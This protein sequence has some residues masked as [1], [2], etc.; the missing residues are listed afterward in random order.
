MRNRFLALATLLAWPSTALADETHSNHFR[1]GQRA[2]GMGG[3]LTAVVGDTEA[4]WYNPAGLAFVSGAVFSGSIQFYGF[5]ERVVNGALR[6]PDAPQ[7]DAEST[8]FLPAPSSS[9]IS[10]EFIRPDANGVG[11]VV[12]ALSTFVGSA[13]EESLSA[14]Q[15]TPTELDGLA[16]IDTRFTSKQIAD[17]ILHTG[18]TVAWRPADRIAVGASLFYVRRDQSTHQRGG[19]VTRQEGT[20]RLDEVNPSQFLDTYS[21]TEVADGALQGK[22]G[23]LWTPTPRWTV[24]FAASTPSLPLHGDGQV[25]YTLTTSGRPDHPR[26]DRRYPAQLQVDARDIDARTEYPWRLAVGLAYAPTARFSLAA[27][28]TLQGAIDYR[29]LKLD[30]ATEGLVANHFVNDVTLNT[31]INAALGLEAWLSPGTVFRAGAFTNRSAAPDIPETADAPMFADV[32]LYG[33]TMSIGFKGDD[34]AVNMGAEFQ[35]GDGDDL[36]LDDV[37]NQWTPAFSRAART[38]QRVLFFVSGAMDFVKK[39]AKRIVDE[40][41]PSARAP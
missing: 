12:I 18:P 31:C 13:Q 25:T 3:A 19:V 9:V 4:T 20:G 8:T 24:G 35:W 22:L 17:R 39:A 2:L 10:K 38:H 5:D 11:G 16:A 40:R 37:R 6:S 27:D 30:A 1:Y 34:R 29:R 28:V 7:S 26:E 41:D 33:V 23:L 36:V 21:Q 15:A 32:D 14:R